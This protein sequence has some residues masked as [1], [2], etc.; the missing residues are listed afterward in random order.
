M[1]RLSNTA[2]TNFISGKG[3]AVFFLTFSYLVQSSIL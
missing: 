1:Q 2:D 3:I